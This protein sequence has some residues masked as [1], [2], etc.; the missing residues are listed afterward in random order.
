MNNLNE[1][2]EIEPIVLETDVDV[3]TEE[4]VADVTEI[5]AH[6]AIMN[7]SIE[8]V[9]PERVNLENLPQ[10]WGGV[11]KKAY[12]ESLARFKVNPQTLTS[13][14]KHDVTKFGASMQS[15]EHNGVEVQC[16][17]FI[18]TSLQKPRYLQED[19]HVFLCPI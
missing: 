6:D 5:D 3:P 7:T 17:D 15:L 14:S 12:L 4:R 2:G 19:G 16:I 9:T 18:H 8:E 11:E 13:F 10:D 1:H